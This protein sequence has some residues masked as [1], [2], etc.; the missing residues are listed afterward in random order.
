MEKAPHRALLK[1]LGLT[2][3]ELEKPLVAIVSAKSEIVQ[4]G[5]AH[6]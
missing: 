2:D 6:V 4:I 3:E 5:R 1:A